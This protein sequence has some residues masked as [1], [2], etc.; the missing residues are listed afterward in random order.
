M[1]GPNDFIP[2]WTQDQV[3]QDYLD[4]RDREDEDEEEIEE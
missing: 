3:T 1:I 4:N 2:D